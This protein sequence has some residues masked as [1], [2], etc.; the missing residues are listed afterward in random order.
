VRH[1]FLVALLLSVLLHLMVLAAPGW[2]IGSGLPD[3]EASPVT[4]RLL[5]PAVKKLP[6]KVVHRAAPAPQPSVVPVLPA[7]PPVEKEQ[8][9]EKLAE[10]VP[11][12]APVELPTE[13]P[14]EVPT[15]APVEPPA[16]KPVE[17]PVEP[18]PEIN[19]V[20]PAA[21]VPDVA[22]LLPR[23]GRIRFSILRGDGGFVVGQSIHEWRHDG[24]RYSIS[25]V[26][27]T[28]GIAAIF[29]PAKVSQ[30]SEGSFL[31]GELKPDSFRFDRGGNDIVTANFD[32]QAQKISL[33]DGQVIAIT[34][35]AEDFLS[36]FYQLM[37]AAQRGEGFVMA[38]ATGR[39]V[40]RYAFEWL[41]EEELVLKPGRYKTWHVRVRAADGGKDTTEVWLGQEVAGLP[42][43]IRNTNRK[44]EV[45]DQVAVEIG[46]EGK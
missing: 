11:T 33:G 3:M 42:V 12:E 39:K 23:S 31:K 7:V 25:A 15:T 22:P 8:E 26:S 2:R 46:Y 40:E 34:D 18:A 37:Q 32:W 14:A 38:V 17:K 27:E 45:F 6:R 35:G 10:A 19:P 4:A 44:G 30:T 9:P 1:S 5:P 16:D 29:K 41:G 20:V 13:V 24:K 43:K 28:T 21:D 36:M